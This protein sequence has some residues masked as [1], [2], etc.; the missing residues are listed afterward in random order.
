M[1][2][3][4]LNSPNRSKKLRKPKD[5][6]FL[7]F[8]Y[9]G[10]QS[11]RAS[12]TRL[13]SLKHKVSCHYLIDRNG[14]I[15]KMVSDLEVAWHAGKSKWKKFTNL[16]EN[17]IGIELVNRGH[18]FGYEKFPKK[19]IL[20]LI[21]ISLTLKKK[22]KIKNS[23]VLGHSDIAP[24]RKID[25]GEKFPWDLLSKKNLGLFHKKKDLKFKFTDKNK[26]RKLF[27]KNIYKIGYR[28]FSKN[29]VSKYDKFIVEAFQR[30]YMP[31]KITGEID[32][33]TLKIS[34]YLAKKL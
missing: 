22:Y 26:Y 16:N 10:M 27:F 4:R 30:R 18:D 14:Q 5:I 25:P 1:I 21:K 19:Q 34:H 15:I 9:T 6:K 13:M 32:Q 12:I 28:Y 3:V 2:N 20:K 7:V 24:L 29:R 31:S 17:S 8:H 33:K 23:C 11:K